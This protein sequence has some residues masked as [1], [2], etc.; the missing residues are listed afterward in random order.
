MKNI[1]GWVFTYNEYRGIWMAAKREDY[2]LLFSDMAN[3]K[4]LSS[5]D[6]V[7]LQEIIERTDGDPVKVKQ[8]LRKGV[9][10]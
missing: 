8:L 1:N 10:I 6:I 5:R 9:K 3:P 4:V 7:T 2:N